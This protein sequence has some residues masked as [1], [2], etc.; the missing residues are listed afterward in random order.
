[1]SKRHVG[2]RVRRRSPRGWPLRLKRPASPTSCR[3]TA[4]ACILKAAEKDKINRRSDRVLAA[5]HQ[6]YLRVIGPLDPSLSTTILAIR[7]HPLPRGISMTDYGTA[8]PRR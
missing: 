8:V 3:T 1:M 2:P 7:R 5:V 6:A 4:A